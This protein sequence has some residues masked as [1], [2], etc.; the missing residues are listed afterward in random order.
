MTKYELVTEIKKSKK[1][2][3]DK[4]ASRASGQLDLE[5]AEALEDFS[6]DMTEISD[7]LQDVFPGWK[8]AWDGPI[9]GQINLVRI[10]IPWEVLRVGVVLR[11][12]DTQTIYIQDTERFNRLVLPRVE[13]ENRNYLTLHLTLQVLAVMMPKL[14]DWKK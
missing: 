8:L 5:Y 14:M 10:D 12:R 11:D 3:E 4:R 13:G 7:A 1:A 9:Q 6:E 2:I